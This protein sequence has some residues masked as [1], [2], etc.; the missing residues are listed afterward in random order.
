M[1]HHIAK[2]SITAILDKAALGTQLRWARAEAQALANEGHKEEHEKLQRWVDH[3]DIAVALVDKKAKD[4]KKD[5]YMKNLKA[6]QDFG[7]VFPASQKELLF[8]KFCDERNAKFDAESVLEFMTC[9]V[10]WQLDRDKQDDLHPDDDDFDVLFPRLR[11]LGVDADEKA[12]KCKARLFAWLIAGIE[13]GEEHAEAFCD[14]IRSAWQFLEENMAE[15]EVEAFDSVVDLF[16]TASWAIVQLRM[17]NDLSYKAALEE[18]MSTSKKRKCATNEC[19]FAAIASAIR[20]SA[21]YSESYEF[22]AKHKNKL[23]HHIP[24]MNQLLAELKA[25]QDVANKPDKISE[26]LDALQRLEADL[27]PEVTQPFKADL[28]PALV[29]VAQEAVKALEGLHGSMEEKKACAA[30]FEKMLDTSMQ[31]LAQ[32][33]P[34][35]HPLHAKVLAFLGTLH[36]ENA[37]ENFHKQAQVFLQSESSAFEI[38]LAMDMKVAMDDFLQKYPEGDGNRLKGQSLVDKLSAKVSDV[39]GHLGDLAAARPLIDLISSMQKGTSSGLDKMAGEM[40]V[41]DAWAALQGSTDAWRALA[42]SANARA[43]KDTDFMVIKAVLQALASAAEVTPQVEKTSLA[44]TFKEAVDAAKDCVEESSDINLKKVNEAVDQALRELRQIAAGSNESGSPWWG[45]HDLRS[46]EYVPLMEL[47]TKQLGSLPGALLVATIA[48]SM[49]TIQDQ[50]STY[51]MFD[52]Q[53]DNDQQAETKKVMSEAIMTKFS[54]MMAAVMGEVS[55]NQPNQKQ[56]RIL[57]NI[58]TQVAGSEFDVQEKFPHAMW[59]KL[60]EFFPASK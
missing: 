44:A 16:M 30:A 55:N 58:K 29:Q 3:A 8:H 40:A 23:A 39:I 9:V 19:H 4:M 49:G 12:T 2:V 18:V 31:R 54:G 38:K 11:S 1:R 48:K 24:I 7:I 52:K 6:L 15:E 10:P 35:L 33:R 56:K 57:R 41:L 51:Q 36:R 50:V 20:K 26:A 60:L 14:A 28:G 22:F 53:I 5:V 37:T 13:A 21:Y 46:M 42:D 25:V 43:A 47:A 32:V 17:T 59:A 34:L 45:D 27:P